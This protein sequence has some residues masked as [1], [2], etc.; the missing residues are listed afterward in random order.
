M[1]LKETGKVMAV[2]QAA[3]PAYYRGISQTDAMAATTL[4]AQM[5]EADNYAEVNAAVLALIA[6]Q[7]QGAPPTIGAVK[8][9]LAQLRQPDRMTAQEAWALAAKAAAGNLAW[10]KLPPMV[11]RAI[12]SP[13]ILVDWGMVPIE[14]FNTVIY[15]QFMKAYKAFDMRERETQLIPPAVQALLGGVADKL[16]LK[17]AEE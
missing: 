9:R 8:A 13:G 1:T 7:T 6:T 17:P 12:G 4:W 15:S 3:F 16:A 10:D 11:Q 14:E 5:F 2:L